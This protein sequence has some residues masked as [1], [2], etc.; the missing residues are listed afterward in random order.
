VGSNLTTNLVGHTA[1]NKTPLILIEMT[2]GR[3]KDST[4]PPSRA[5]IIQRE[6]RDRKAKHLSDLKD[7]CHKAEEENERLRK[8][9]ELARSGSAVVSINIEL[10]NRAPRLFLASRLT[11]L[12]LQMKPTSCR[13][14]RALISCRIWSEPKRPSRSF[15][16]V[17][18]VRLLHH[19]NHQNQKGT[20]DYH[21][22]GRAS[23]L[24]SLLSP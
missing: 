20:F 19:Q 22:S 24:I 17:R 11:T 5:L 7:R 6:Y 1:P 14:E 8:E 23:F 3:R 16:N 18:S 13:P 15:S 4:L 12:L 10:V 2:R 9:L 21:S